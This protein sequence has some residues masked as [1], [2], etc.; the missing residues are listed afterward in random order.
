MNWLPKAIPDN[1]LAARLPPIN[2]YSKVEQP[3]PPRLNNK[4]VYFGLSS[5]IGFQLVFCPM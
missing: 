3:K 1:G 5:V 2:Y 4:M